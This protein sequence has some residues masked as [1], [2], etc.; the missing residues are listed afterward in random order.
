M[1]EALDAFEAG[2]YSLAA[3]T[4]AES[5][6]GSPPARLLLGASYFYAGAL[7]E[8]QRIFE[9]LVPPEL[10]RGAELAYWD[11]FRSGAAYYLARLH[12]GA[13]NDAE[14]LRLAQLAQSGSDIWAE[15]AKHLLEQR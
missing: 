6:E 13:G 4:I 12:L 5:A 9:E 2:D 8:A 3:S 1:A 15:A 7:S 11:S 10:G 14:G